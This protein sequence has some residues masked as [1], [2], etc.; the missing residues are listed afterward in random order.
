MPLSEALTSPSP[1]LSIGK[2]RK[3]L[4]KAGQK[5]ARCEACG[6]TS[7]RGRALTF[8]LDHVDGDR[9]NNLLSNLRMLCPNCHAQTETWCRKKPHTPT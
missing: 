7:W 1:Y 6:I 2:L 9:T 8:E 5:E 3:R 4:L